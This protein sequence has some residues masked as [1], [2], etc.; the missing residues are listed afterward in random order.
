MC[1]NMHDCSVAKGDT[2]L[3]KN[4]DAYAQWAKTNNSLLV[5]TFDENAGGTVN[6][7]ATLI[8]GSGVKPGLYDDKMDHYTLLRTI[9]H[10]YELEPIGKAKDEQPLTDI[11]GQPTDEDP[12]RAN[13]LINGGF[14]DGLVG[15]A[16]SGTTSLSSQ[17]RT[18]RGAWS[19]STG[20][21][22]G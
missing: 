19:A 1:N 10:L 21:P 12:V 18:T 3:K 9:E 7:I 6:Q 22:R 13:D 8:V 4:F 16:T 11:F 5:V 14:E 15:W 17:T 20:S 2:W